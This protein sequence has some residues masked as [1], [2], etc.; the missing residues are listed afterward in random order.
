MSKGTI[1]RWWL[2]RGPGLKGLRKFVRQGE[3]ILPPG[4][5][6]RDSEYTGENAIEA[7]HEVERLRTKLDPMSY[8]EREFPTPHSWGEKLKLRVSMEPERNLDTM[9]PNPRAVEFNK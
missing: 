2:Y 1:Y 4:F 8:T 5:N 6:V 9:P 3:E 7:A